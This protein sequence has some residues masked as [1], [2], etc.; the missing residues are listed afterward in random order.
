MA[1]ATGV[2]AMPGSDFAEA[3]KIIL[4]ELP[5]LPHLPE[6]P[7]RGVASAMIGRT[8]GLIDHLGF[9][10]QPAGWRLTDASGIDQRRARSRLNQ[11]LDLL[12]EMMQG[13]SGAFKAQV[14][15]PWSLAACVERSRGDKILGDQGACR[16]LVQALAEAVSEHVIDLRRRLPGADLILQVDEP[17]LPAVLSGSIPNASGLHR[18]RAVSQARASQ[19]LQEVYQSISAAGAT[20]LTHCCASDTPITLIREAGSL[21]SF[22]P[23]VLEAGR[24]EEFAASLD[25]EQRVFLGIAPTPII[26]DWRVRELLDSLYRLL[27]MVGI[28]PREASDYLVLTPACGLSASGLSSSGSTSVASSL[29]AIHSAAQ[30]VGA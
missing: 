19:A 8:L 7:D 21:V 18:Q 30:E 22:D 12:E 13:Y 28:D 25:A 4:G 9:D 14:V 5:D 3:L 1:I 26:S 27:D 17:V 11:D 16:E 10:L 24:L 20:A 2:G 23:R 29:G 15:G 6:L